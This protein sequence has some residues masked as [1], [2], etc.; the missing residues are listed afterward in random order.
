MA[1]MVL[2][3]IGSSIISDVEESLHRAGISVAAGIRNQ[4]G[5]SY[6]SPGVRV[7]PAEQLDAE[8][9][10]LPF[11]VP[12]F[13]PGNRQTAAQQAEKLGL[14]LPFTLIDP[15]VSPP[16][17]LF[18]ESGSYINVGCSLG[19]GSNFGRY[20]FINRGASIGHHV[21][22]DA[23][24]SLGP[25]VVLGAHVKI[26]RGSTIGAGAT[27]LPS[28]KIGNNAVVGAGAVVTRDVPDECLVFGNPARLIRE[29]IGGY[30]GL[31]VV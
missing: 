10:A 28:I 2:F 24:V 25:G 6:L 14:S 19:A 5:E 31:R 4:P 1:G 15:S 30:K 12:L 18:V 29:Q 3:G 11:L 9:T 8:L 20:T 17:Q 23:F 13:T 22:L 27:I 16:R 7:V 26:G 21:R